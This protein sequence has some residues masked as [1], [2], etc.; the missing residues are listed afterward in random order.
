MSAETMLDV[1]MHTTAENVLVHR[2]RVVR[3]VPFPHNVTEADLAAAAAA[4]TTKTKKL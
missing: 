1:V 4:A 3:A 2:H